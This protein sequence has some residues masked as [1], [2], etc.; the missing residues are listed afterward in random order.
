MKIRKR[1]RTKTGQ[2]VGDDPRTKDIDEAWED[3]AEQIGKD[4]YSGAYAKQK[5]PRYETIADSISKRMS[6]YFTRIKK[7]FSS[8]K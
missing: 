8:K 3:T 5:K 1:A 2:Y 6:D 7:K 4:I